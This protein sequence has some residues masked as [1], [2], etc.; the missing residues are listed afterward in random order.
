MLSA[1]VGW[2]L[3]SP[4]YGFPRDDSIETVITAE[5]IERLYAEEIAQLSA[6]H[7][8]ADEA[9]KARLRSE[10][11]AK[12][13]ADE[14]VVRAR[15]ETRRRRAPIDYPY[16]YSRVPRE[17]GSTCSMSTLEQ[18]RAGLMRCELVSPGRTWDALEYT[19][20]IERR[21][22]TFVLAILTLEYAD[23]RRRLR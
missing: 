8:A 2:G 21:D 19:R 16:S 10:L 15:I 18:S 14:I 6:L 17:T 12:L 3:G 4:K 9:E 20:A 11:D 5:A 1:A 22:D 7:A 13:A 23:L